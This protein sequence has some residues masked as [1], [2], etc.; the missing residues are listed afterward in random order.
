[1]NISTHPP[2]WQVPHMTWR[3]PSAPSITSLTRASTVIPKP[4]CACTD[5]KS[6]DRLT[7]AGPSRQSFRDHCRRLLIPRSCDCRREE[8]EVAF[9][10]GRNKEFGVFSIANSR[11]GLAISWQPALPHAAP[12]RQ[13]N[14]QPFWFNHAE[15]MGSMGL[16]GAS[17]RSVTPEVAGSSPVAPAQE[18]PGNGAFSIRLRMLRFVAVDRLWQELARSLALSRIDLQSWQVFPGRPGVGRPRMTKR[19]SVRVP[20]GQGPV[21]KV[22]RR[23]TTCPKRTFGGATFRLGSGVLVRL[24]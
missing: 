11:Q 15:T 9:F 1:M 20:A 12:K 19:L 16:G 17:R 2:S 13:G 7:S 4:D 6:L 24:G 18:G 3:P 21:V 14:L 23:R 22:V 5:N 10:P 8:P